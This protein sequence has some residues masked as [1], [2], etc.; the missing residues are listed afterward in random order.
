M[1]LCTVEG[2]LDRSSA[3]AIVAKELK[4]KRYQSDC[5]VLARRLHGSSGVGSIEGIY[6]R[7]RMA[8]LLSDDRAVGCTADDVESA[9]QARVYQS[10]YE[11]LLVLLLVVLLVGMA[12]KMSF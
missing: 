12:V 9:L 3:L 5:W 2:R 8:D 11:G 7:L 1:E 6:A 4:L 10:C